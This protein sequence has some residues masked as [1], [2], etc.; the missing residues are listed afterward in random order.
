MGVRL[1]IGILMCFL[2][3]LPGLGAGLLPAYG[4]RITG[5]EGVTS[6]GPQGTERAQRPVRP[7]PPPSP[8]RAPAPAAPSPEAGPDREDKEPVREKGT[9]EE[10]DARAERFVTIDFDNVDIT[11]FIKF[12]SELTGKNFVVD[13]AVRGNVTI[14]SPT[15]ISVDE[16]YKVFESVLEVHG[17]T[18]VPAGRVIKI[19]P[20]VK[21]RSKSVETR[22]KEEAAAPEDKVVTQLIPLKYADPDELKK[23]FTPLVSRSS[24]IVSYPPTGM[25]IVTD[26]L[27][28][29][30]RLLRITG[31]ID[32]EGTGEEISVVP[33]EYASAPEMAKSLTALFQ[34]TTR[35]VGKRAV[36]MGP[37]IKVAADE[38]TNVLI[39]MASETDMLKLK[40]LIGLLD[41]KTPRGGEGVYVYYLQHATAED[42]AA[43][44]TALPSKEGQKNQK[45]KAPVVSKG[46]QIVADKATN[47]LIITAKKEDYLVLEGVIQKLD[48]PRQMVYIEALIM[49]VNVNKDFDLGVEWRV[50]DQVGSHDGGAIAPFAGSGGI[51]EGGAYSLFPGFSTTAPISFPNAFS[52]G[53]LGAGIKVGD[54]VFPTLGAVLQAYQKDKDVHILSTPQLMTTDNEEAEIT[55]GKNVPYVTRQETSSI[56]LD[57]SSYEYK[58]VGVTLKITP[59]ISQERFVRLAIYQEVTRLIVDKGLEEGRPTTYKRLAQTTVVIKDKHTVVIG[60][61]IDD[62]T[63]STDYKVPC[64]GNIPGLGWLFKSVSRTREKTNLYVFLTP[65]IIDNP[66]QAREVYREKKEQIDRI[67]E[68]VIKMY[69]GRT[70]ETKDMRLSNL[71][72]ERLKEGKTD[73]AMKY[74]I[75]ALQI[76][77]ENPYA[78]LNMGVIYEMQGKINEAMDMYQRIITLN[79]DERAGVATDPNKKG[80]KL[81][82]IARDNL[83]GLKNRNP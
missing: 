82:D 44:L 20:S 61:L 51:G 34:R 76:N 46:V 64:L 8:P 57:Y 81:V 28:N 59:Q 4:A 22:L 18:T 83:E 23:L 25:L 79:P 39:V 9:A 36:T 48:I 29:I 30:D 77:P 78:L 11:L 2:W 56:E 55:V 54:F 62:S 63:Q 21:A 35:R 12:I 14:I 41:K 27:S 47:S 16:A 24:V 50:A 15:K 58:D 40:K 42:L 1:R 52:L 65:H 31:V 3:S 66:A 67:R 69:E 17:F 5:Q 33:L 73:E 43:V 26:V 13:K 60:G 7:R 10:K 19:V 68:G 49:E 80:R 53:I 70:Q 32:V 38:R 75:E 45:G 71:G 72:Y 6:A 37:S 74:F